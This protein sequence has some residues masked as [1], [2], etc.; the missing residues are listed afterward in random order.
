VQG[1]HTEAMNNYRV[2]YHTDPTYEP[3]RENIER[4]GGIDQRRKPIN[5]GD[6]KEKKG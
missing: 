5:L 2:A 3:A 1:Q 4:A 6:L